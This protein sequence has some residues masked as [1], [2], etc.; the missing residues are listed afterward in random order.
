VVWKHLTAA[1]KAGDLK[2]AAKAKRAVEQAQRDLAGPPL[3]LPL[4]RRPACL[5]PHAASAARRRVTGWLLGGAAARKKNKER[6]EPSFFELS[7]SSNEARKGQT[8][9]STAESRWLPR[10]EAILAF[11]AQR[12]QVA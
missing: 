6:F 8:S 10:R 7:P 12:M 3:A 5:P 9:V 11:H 4:S 1:L 2:T